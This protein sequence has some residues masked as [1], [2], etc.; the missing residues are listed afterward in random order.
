LFLFQSLSNKQ[1]TD[2][3]FKEI[4]TKY[5]KYKAGFLKESW[6]DGN[7]L[8]HNCEDFV[9]ERALEE[10]GVDSK[11]AQIA[12]KHHLLAIARE[13]PVNFKTWVLSYVDFGWNFF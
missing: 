13:E 10:L 8:I 2:F 11:L 1:A 3:L 7:Y 5:R 4:P 6:I 12:I 9:T